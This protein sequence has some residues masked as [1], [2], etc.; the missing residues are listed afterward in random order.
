MY[1]SKSMGLTAPIK[2]V[3]L[4]IPV[5]KEFPPLLTCFLWDL[6]REARAAN[7]D[8]M[9]GCLSGNCHVDDGRNFLVR[10]FL[11]T[12]CDDLFFLDADVVGNAAEITRFMA[13]DRDVSAVL[14]PYKSD[15]FGFPH[16]IPPETAVIEEADGMIEVPMVPTGC[17]KIKRHVLE[18]LDA[19]APHC[20]GQREHGTSKNPMPI[21]FERGLIDKRRIGGD[22]H[23]CVKWQALGGKIYVEPNVS[24]GHVG[25]K[26][27]EGEFGQYLASENGVDHPYFVKSVAALKAGNPE[28]KDF[29]TIRA[30][31]GNHFAVGGDMLM[32]LW[33]IVK[34]HKGTILETG[35]GIT[36][37]VMGIAA[38]QVG[39]HVHAL[40]HDAHYFQQTLSLL[41]RYGVDNVTLHYAPLT[42]KRGG[43]LWYDV[44]ASLPHDFTVAINDGPP[45]NYGGSHA[46][47]GFYTIVGDRIAESHWIGDDADS[48]HDREMFERYATADGRECHVFGERGLRQFIV[49]KSKAKPRLMAAE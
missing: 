45:R 21:I 10:E 39:A 15:E 41:N 37:L 32:A 46:R 6:Q 34:E 20:Y 42:D 26:V 3:Y 23:F 22:Y 4:A 14:Y 9:L 24:L 36:T 18:K 25:E 28:D 44:P 19:I 27:Y 12:D 30:R 1:N 7:I 5:S 33:E 48:D 43:M 17:L 29:A 11:E 16:L 35:S 31:W 49:A 47:E 38:D 40:E 13:N 8:I 2:R